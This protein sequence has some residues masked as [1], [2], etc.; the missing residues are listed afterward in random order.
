MFEGV[1]V[2]KGHL[3]SGWSMTLIQRYERLLR[4]DP[5]TPTEDLIRYRAIW[6]VGLMF[7]VMQLINLTVISIDHGEWTYDHTICTITVVCIATAVH[8]LRWYKN[9][10]VY[11]VI[12]SAM[13]FLGMI[14]SALPQD[15]GI[16][17]A[18][19]PLLIV[20]P[21]LCGYISGRRAAIIFWAVGT[22][23]ICFLAWVTWDSPVQW[24]SGERHRDLNRATNAFYFMTLSATLSAMLTGR[25]FMALR[26]MRENA[27]RAARAEAAQSEF[28][29]KM[30]HELRTPLHGIIGL[31][32]VLIR[33]DL[34]RREKELTE[35]LR[36]SGDSL[37]LILNDLL[38]LSKI[39]A[40]KM[41]ITLQPAN[42]RSALEKD[43]QGWA[44]VAEARGLGF[45][46]SLPDELNIGAELD[47]LRLRQVV[48]NLVSNAVKYT[49]A[50]EV[51]FEAELT[52][53]TN[54]SAVLKMRVTDTGNGI[55]PEAVPRIFEAFVQGD[56]SGDNVEGGTGL[57]LP[58]SRML[59]ELMGGELTLERTGP[60]GS[61]FCACLP[62]RCVEQPED[63]EDDTVMLSELGELRALVVEDHEVNKLVL[64]EYLKI[65]GV[66]FEMVADGV[67]CLKRLENN[68]F[69][70]ILMDKNMPRLNG[71]EATRA[72]RESGK[73]FANI[74]VV[75]VTADAMVGERERLLAGGMDDFI[76]KP[77]RIDELLR[78][79]QEAHL[80]KMSAAGMPAVD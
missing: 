47:E 27:E 35:T 5:E 37:L 57:G 32:D 46:V 42:L 68:T 54:D 61:V 30:S 40:G 16:N 69:D 44:E 62:L 55:S 4:I 41:T 64:G 23:V 72:I 65:L 53:C 29:A 26:K 36:E 52:D 6:L 77:L 19:V 67:E 60:E 15:A 34:N 74:Y 59:I 51:R 78:V 56:V 71:V 2:G 58:I 13:L 21:L 79:M 73:H 66:D 22:L 33:S 12:F 24:A 45:V 14:A 1:I 31:T 18:L 63:E 70:V 43:V 7:V 20:G 9:Y 80:R 38:D 49:D 75:A 8:A 3:R 50:G 39:E 10:D 11:A 76:S 25:T 28:L 48:H 17:S